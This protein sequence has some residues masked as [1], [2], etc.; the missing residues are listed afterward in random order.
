VSAIEGI[1]DEIIENKAS[2]KSVH[3]KPTLLLTGER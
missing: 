3:Q 2:D 1:N